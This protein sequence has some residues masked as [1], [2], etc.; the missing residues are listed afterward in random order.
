[1]V[2]EPALQ[3][4]T[5]V[6]RQTSRLR[7]ERSRLAG[8][9]CLWELD[10]QTDR[11]LD[12]FHQFRATSYFQGERRAGYRP[13]SRAAGL[14]FTALLLPLQSS[15]HGIPRHR[16]QP[17]SVGLSVSGQR[18]CQRLVWL[19]RSHEQQQQRLERPVFPSAQFLI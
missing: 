10:A 2:S 12:E 17:G 7:S 19:L 1:M 14:Q 6:D 16:I 15:A 18:S 4:Q 11:R 8:D 5:P 9:A 13:V 3:M